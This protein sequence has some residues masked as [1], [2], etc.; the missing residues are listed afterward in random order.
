MNNKYRLKITG[1]NPNRFI[2]YLIDEKISLYDVEINIKDTIIL[3]DEDGYSKI[4]KLKT[5]YK[6]E[7]IDEYGF[8]KYRHLFKKY[9]I[10][11]FCVFFGVLLIKFLSTIVFDIDVEHS[12]S[13]IRDL[14]I[15]DLKLY[16][17]EKY[18]FKVSYEEK[19]EIIKKILKKET[20]KS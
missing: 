14:I 4:L 16:G 2:N 8:I 13:E 12:K 15:D 6:V 11:L 7:L 17:I 1:K 5:S 19:E 10:F 20:D 3:V 9:S 18:H